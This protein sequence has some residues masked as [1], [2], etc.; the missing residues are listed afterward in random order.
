MQQQLGSSTMEIDF[1]KYVQQEPPSETRP[2]DV[3]LDMHLVENF[4]TELGAI[5]PIDCYESVMIEFITCTFD[6]I[7]VR[8]LRQPDRPPVLTYHQVHETPGSRHRSS[9]RIVHGIDANGQLW[10]LNKDGSYITANNFIA[11]CRTLLA[12]EKVVDGVEFL[13]DMLGETIDKEDDE[14][15]EEDDDQEDFDDEEDD[16]DDVRR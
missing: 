12:S 14:F 7:E 9:S 6:L 1:D 2:F 16:D 10:F 11:L 15:D 3:K 5:T 8:D 4:S 13:Q